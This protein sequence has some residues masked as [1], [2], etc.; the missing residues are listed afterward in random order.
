MGHKAVE[1]THT[2]NAFGLGTSNECTVQWWFKKFCKGNENPEDEECGHQP[3]EPDN[4]K[5]RAVIEADAL[6]TT[7]EVV[8]ELRVDHSLVIWHLKQIGKVKKLDKWMPHELTKNQKHHHSEVSC[9]ILFNNNEPFLYQIVMCNEK[10]IVYDNQR[11]PAQWLDLEEAPKNFPKQNLLQRKVIVTIWCV[12]SITAF[13]IP[14]KSLYLRSMLSKSMRCTENCNAYS[15]WSTEWV[16]FFSMTTPNHMSYKQHFKNWMNWA[17]KFYLIHVFT[18]PLANQLPL[19]Q[20][21]QQLFAGEML[22]QPAGGRKCFL[23]VHQTRKHRFLCYRD[24]QTYFF[25]AKLCWL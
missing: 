11:W 19:L 20:A 18:W 16:Q 7:W 9:L 21:S 1:I 12:W 13:W 25:L 3:P 10:W 6:A 2:Y 4:D 8:E 24:K 5:L 22:P 17:T 14:A 15:Q 23:R